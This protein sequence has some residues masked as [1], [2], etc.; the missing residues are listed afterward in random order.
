M[1]QTFD[2][3]RQSGCLKTILAAVALVALLAF[4]GRADYNEEVRS[5]MGRDTYR[6]IG[7]YLG[8][9]ATETDIVEE[10]TSITANG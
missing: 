8:S 10:Y 7:A 6:A 1:E 5:E 4:A 2:L 9:G 3:D